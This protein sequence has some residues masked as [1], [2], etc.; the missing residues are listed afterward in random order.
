MHRG[1]P[2]VLTHI[3]C[4]VG[5]KVGEE[6]VAVWAFDQCMNARGKTAT[7]SGGCAGG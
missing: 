7:E 6:G 1:D 4:V 3:L 2:R 5:E